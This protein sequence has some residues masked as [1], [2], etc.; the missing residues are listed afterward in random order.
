MK[1]KNEEGFTLMEVLFAMAIFSVGLFA[2]S[3]MQAHFAKGLA[4]SRHIINA[5]DIAMSKIEDLSNADSSDAA[6]NLGPHSET[7]NDYNIPYTIS[8]QVSQKNIGNTL[9]VPVRVSWT[10]EG[11]VH[12]VRFSWVRDL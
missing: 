9:S 1:N 7:N 11:K 3:M 10:L 6:F 5:T 12:S 4:D 8:W 2:L